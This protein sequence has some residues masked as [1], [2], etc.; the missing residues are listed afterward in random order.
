MVGVGPSGAGRCIPGSRCRLQVS[1][2]LRLWWRLRRACGGV[3]SASWG[4]GWVSEQVPVACG[5]STGA[6]RSSPPGVPPWADGKLPAGCGQG[7]GP[8]HLVSPGRSAVLVRGRVPNAHQAFFRAGDSPLPRMRSSAV[9]ASSVT[10]GWSRLLLMAAAGSVVLV[11]VRAAPV[12]H[13]SGQGCERVPAAGEALAPPGVA[14]LLG[15]PSLAVGVLAAR[16]MWVGVRGG[17]A[18]PSR[19]Q[20]RVSVDVRGAGRVLPTGIPAAAWKRCPAGPLRAGP[21]LCS[22]SWERPRAQATAAP[23]SGS[24]CRP[25]SGAPWASSRATERTGPRSRLPAPK[26]TPPTRSR[27]R[28]HR[29]PEA[30]CPAEPARGTRPRWRPRGPR[31]PSQSGQQYREAAGSG[32]P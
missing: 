5:A 7:R 28:G 12:E 15:V 1:R 19:P 27:D 32:S 14:H 3:L 13:C 16:R 31:P 2:W 22:T 6:W 4:P 29:Y 10:R 23:S 8:E 30:G 21:Q 20:R 25:W 18:A 11:A 17:D 26:T 24:A 9:E